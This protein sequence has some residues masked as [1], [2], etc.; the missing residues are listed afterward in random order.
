MGKA[1]RPYVLFMAL[2]IAKVSEADLLTYKIIL[3]SYRP[4]S[5]VPI[6]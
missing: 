1:G 4:E 6:L 5:G 2:R 3:G